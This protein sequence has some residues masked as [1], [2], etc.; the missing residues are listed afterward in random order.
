MAIIVLNLMTY[1]LVNSGLARLW[2]MVEYEV[3]DETGCTVLHFFFYMH[4]ECAVQ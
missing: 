1:S 3:K 2:M 4:L